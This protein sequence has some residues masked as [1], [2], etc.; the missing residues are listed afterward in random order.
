[1]KTCATASPYHASHAKKG[2]LSGLTL[3]IKWFEALA[4]W[5]F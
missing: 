3:A 4:K 5:K 1:A 2:V